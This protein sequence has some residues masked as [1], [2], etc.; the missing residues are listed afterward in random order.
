MPNQHVVVKRVVLSAEVWVFSV[1]LHESV[2]L[3]SLAVTQH[4]Q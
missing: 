4:V 2:P 3:L 1:F